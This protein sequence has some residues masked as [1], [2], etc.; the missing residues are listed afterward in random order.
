[1]KAVDLNH[2][3]TIIF[4]LGQVIVDLD[5]KAVISKLQ[6]FSQR[7]DINYKEL[8]VS[9][10]LLQEY[11]TGKIDGPSFREG[12]IELLGLK[13]SHDTFDEIWNAMLANI[14][15]TRLRLMERLSESHTTMILSNTNAIHEARF[16]EMV[17]EQ[18]PGKLMKDFV[19]HAYYSHDI[20][21]RKPDPSI[22]QYVIETHQLN[23]SKT[24]FLDDREDNITSAK[25]LGI[26]AVQVDYPDQI[27]EI[28]RHE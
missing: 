14:P 23:P 7:D 2:I 25:T 9:S 20:G 21:Y 10:P 13:I 12:L 5:S 27:F 1:M 3:E 17:G 18:V 22:Y 8:I 4:D 28:L 16:D 11:E 19:H 15:T 26:M 6:A 24:L